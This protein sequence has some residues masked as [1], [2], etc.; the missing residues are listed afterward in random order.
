VPLKPDC[1]YVAGE[2]RHLRVQKD[3]ALPSP[4]ADELAPSADVLF[5]SVAAAYGPEALGIV[6]T[7][8]GEDGANGL[9]ALRQA[10]AW[11]IGQDRASSVVYGMPRVALEAG[12]L[13]ET[14]AL[15][16]IARRVIGLVTRQQRGAT[17]P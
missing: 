6:L 12:A 3:V 17:L 2:K 1:I 15:D 13:C 11:T 4:A 10:G 14:V 5:H 7:G 9:R 16:E 8:M